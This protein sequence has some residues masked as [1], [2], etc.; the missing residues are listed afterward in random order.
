M[1]LAIGTEIGVV[2]HGTLVPIALDEVAATVFA[3]RAIAVDTRMTATSAGRVIQG[4]V[5]WHEAMLRVVSSGRLDT[6][7]AVIKVGTGQALVAD[8]ENALLKG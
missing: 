8:T 3:E 1:S 5:Q 7:A 6:D 2:A 4:F